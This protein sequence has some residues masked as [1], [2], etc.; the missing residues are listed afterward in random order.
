MTSP[1]SSRFDLVRVVLVVAAVAAVSAVAANAR[2][3]APAA[4]CGG[5]TP[6]RGAPILR[7]GPLRVAGFSSDRCAGIVLGCGVAHG[8]WQAPLS[9][10]VSQKLKSPVVL[11]ASSRAVSFVL[12]GNTTPAPKVPRCQPSSKARAPVTLRPPKM[13]F[14]LF[15]FAP[16]NVKFQLTATRGGRNV[17]TAVFSA[18]RA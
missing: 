18:V 6:L 1:A 16:R 8:G 10:E 9:I 5:A 4:S 13:Y 2:V 11:R 12:V 15:V 3:R 7:L 14:V 17:G